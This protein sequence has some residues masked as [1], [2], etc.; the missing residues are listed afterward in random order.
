MLT[1]RIAIHYN[2]AALCPTWLSFLDRVMDRQQDMIDY[3]QRLAGYS[4]TGSVRDKAFIVLY[5][6][7]DNGKTTFVE[8]IEHI[9]GDT[10]TGGYATKA[11]TSMLMVKR[12]QG[13]DVPTDIADLK[14]ARFVHT[15]EGQENARLNEALIKE[16][17]GR[18]TLTARFM[19]QDFFRF[20]ATHKLWFATNHKPE[21]RGTDRAIWE[22]VKLIPF[23]VSIPKEEQDGDLPDKLKAEAPGILT[24]MVDGC[25][26]WQER[27]L[28]DPPPVAQATQNYRE[29]MDVIGRFIEDRCT[30]KDF[31]TVRAGQLYAA[32]AAWCGGN[33]EFAVKNRRFGESM[34]ER[35]F[36]RK[37]EE[38]G[39]WYRGIGLNAAEDGDEG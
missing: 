8:T 30:C 4:L 19:R 27:G 13:D 24:W 5:G 35:G 22:R 12:A 21:I 20:H 33:G 15:A 28:D 25:L 36:L 7:G 23:T 32:Y 14:G 3:L 18:D 11:P 6:E 26:K 9:L 1:R 34:I 39:N 37:K 2:P 17:T 16:L 38:S 29:A 10:A 31:T